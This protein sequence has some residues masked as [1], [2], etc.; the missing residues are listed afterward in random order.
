[1]QNERRMR[2]CVLLYRV[3]TICKQSN[4]YPTERK[5]SSIRPYV[6]W[7]IYQPSKNIKKP[8][9]YKSNAMSSGQLQ[10]TPYPR[11]TY[12]HIQ[13][14]ITHADTH[15]STH[16]VYTKL[17]L[18]QHIKNRNKK[19]GVNTN[20]KTP[21]FQMPPLVHPFKTSPYIPLPARP[22]FLHT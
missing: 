2:P 22:I 21:E 9:N 15:L 10:S 14:P 20:A 17:P 16:T 13:K 18:S 4:A 3:Y 12:K 19:Q 8:L 6:I 11:H 5:T 7:S 1:M